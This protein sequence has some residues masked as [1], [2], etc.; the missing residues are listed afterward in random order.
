[1]RDFSHDFFAAV[2]EPISP[3]DNFFRDHFGTREVH[4][5]GNLLEN[6]LN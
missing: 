3:S 5:E 4:V 6:Q 2:E 1:M